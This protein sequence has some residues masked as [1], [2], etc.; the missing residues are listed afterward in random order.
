LAQ[1]EEFI[2]LRL[3]QVGLPYGFLVLGFF[4]YALP[5]TSEH[6]G[7]GFFFFVLAR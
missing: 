5:E 7:V 2:F 4:L 1:F 6:F 3:L